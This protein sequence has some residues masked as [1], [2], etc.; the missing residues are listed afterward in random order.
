MSADVTSPEPLPGWFTASLVA[1]LCIG[2]L[3]ALIGFLLAIAGSAMNRCSAFGDFG[4]GGYLVLGLLACPGS[5]VAGALAAGLNT[6]WMSKTA[7]RYTRRD[8][9]KRSFALAFLSMFL[10]GPV[11]ISVL[12]SL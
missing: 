2:A 3:P 11:S 12:G 8:A 9:W 10:G 5:A 4:C 1:G 7:N 6:A